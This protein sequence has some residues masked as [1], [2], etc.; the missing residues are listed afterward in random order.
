MQHEMDT[1]TDDDGGKTNNHHDRGQNA[2]GHNQLAAPPVRRSG[3]KRSS[4]DSI[5]KYLIFIF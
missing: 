4:I 2:N 5:C 3:R 1:D